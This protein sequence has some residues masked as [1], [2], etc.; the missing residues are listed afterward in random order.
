[1]K[2]FIAVILAFVSFVSLG[3]FMPEALAKQLTITNTTNLNVD[4]LNKEEDPNLYC[5][6]QNIYQK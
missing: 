3:E 2:R 5:L 6:A 1:M 4:I